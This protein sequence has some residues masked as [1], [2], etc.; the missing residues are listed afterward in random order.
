M[1]GARLTGT[2]FPGGGG[3]PGD[4]LVALL[5]ERLTE[6]DSPGGGGWAE[7]L[8]LSPSGGTSGGGVEAGEGPP[9][10][11]VWVL[12]LEE[13]VLVWVDMFSLSVVG[14]LVCWS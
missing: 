4:D 10:D 5:G 9:F 6:T 7:P 8:E 12:E 11:A 3:W 13:T 2:D 14:V 1:L